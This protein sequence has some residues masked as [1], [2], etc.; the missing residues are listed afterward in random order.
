MFIRP[1]KGCFLLVIFFLNASANAQESIPVFKTK[2]D[3][4]AYYSTQHAIRNHNPLAPKL[5]RMDS[6]W[7]VQQRIVRTGILGWKYSYKPDPTFVMLDDVIS[8]KVAT[9]DVK[10]LSIVNYT[11]RKLPDVVWK[12]DALEEI[13]L[14]NTTIEKL[15][16]H[17]NKLNKLHSIEVFNN[18]PSKRLKLSKNGNVTYLKFRSDQPG[19]VPVNYKKFKALDSLD[20]SRNFLTEFPVIDQNKHL[21]QLMLTDNNITLKNLRI[22][23]NNSLQ[24]LYMRRNKIEILPDAI[25]NLT[26]L[27]K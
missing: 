1:Q 23:P 16:K 20:L 26:A 17:L 10:K 25:G 14:I 2:S 12:C 6:L 19:K 24:T 22:R 9:K 7:E 21:R 13:E 27:K 4:V 8:G 11:E 15:P 5:I 18:S 3:S